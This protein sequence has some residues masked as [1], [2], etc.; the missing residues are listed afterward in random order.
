MGSKEEL[1]SDDIK[2]FKCGIVSDLLEGKEPKKLDYISKDGLT[3]EEFSRIIDEMIEYKLI[4]G[5][6]STKDCHNSRLANWWDEA[7]V[8]SKGRSFYETFMNRL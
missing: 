5:V 6:V 2:M 3:E 8:T 4:T 1:N 7:E